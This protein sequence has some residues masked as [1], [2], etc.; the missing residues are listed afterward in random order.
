MQIWCR[1]LMAPPAASDPVICQS[2]AIIYLP[3]VNISI[4]LVLARRHEQLKKVIQNIQIM[5]IVLSLTSSARLRYLD[6]RYV[7][8]HTLWIPISIFFIKFRKKN[9]CLFHLWATLKALRPGRQRYSYKRRIA[10]IHGEGS[11]QGLMLV[12]SAYQLALSHL[13]HHY[14][15][16]LNRC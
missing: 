2:S 16:I 12:R 7:Q 8:I 10:K 6:V 15:T 4:G 11:K 13:R 9:L 1:M 5:I 3:K 14:D